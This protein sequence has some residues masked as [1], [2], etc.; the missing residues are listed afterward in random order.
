MRLKASANG[1]VGVV[2]RSKRSSYCALARACGPR[3]A[4]WSGKLIAAQV[5]P[6]SWLTR[7]WVMVCVAY[8]G[9]VIACADAT[10]SS[11]H[12]QANTSRA[13][14]PRIQSVLVAA[15]RSSSAGTHSV[16]CCTCRPA[17]GR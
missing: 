6:L 13:R 8:S 5:A 7:A 11:Q 3:F 17:Y 14:M 15:G 4:Q 9:A 1:P 16:E 10:G 12:K 2:A